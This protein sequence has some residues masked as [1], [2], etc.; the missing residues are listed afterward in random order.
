[1]VKWEKVLTRYVNVGTNLADAQ[2]HTFQALRDALKVIEDNFEDLTD[3]EIE[4]I[5]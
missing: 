4:Y 2:E 1:M 3:F 5:R